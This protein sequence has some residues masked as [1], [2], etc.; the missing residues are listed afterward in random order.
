MAIAP[1][2]W[3]CWH[4]PLP[5]AR[6][7]GPVVAADPVEQ[8]LLTHDTT[9]YCWYS[10]TVTLAEAGEHALELMR[11]GDVFAVYLDGQCVAR[12]QG[13]F[14]ENR[15]ST[16]PGI[17]GDASVNPLEAQGG[18][19]FHHLFRFTAAEGEHQLDILAASLGLT[20]GDWMVSGPMGNERKGIWGSVLLDGV[21]LHDW[22]MRPG[23]WGER[24]D[25]PAQPHAAEWQAVSSDAPSQPLTWYE[26]EFSLTPEQLAADADFRLAADGLGKGHLYLNGHA[27]GRHWL[28]EAVGYG[29]DAGWHKLELD[30]LS[31][32]PAGEPTQRCY[33]LPRPW[34]TAHNRL[35]ICEELACAPHQLTVEWRPWPALQSG[36]E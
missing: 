13:P 1:T 31:L 20:K 23:L 3:C 10:S 29:G 18:D 21:E 24:L 9:D 32:D 17:T 4:E 30:G 26:T 11:G 19:G 25:L 12:S 7:D 14:L 6:P 28:I 15:G 16:L 22:R 2:D 36:T 33:H 35:V 27:L 5:K 34:L 8:L